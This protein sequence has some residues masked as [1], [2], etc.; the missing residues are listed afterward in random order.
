MKNAI[1]F[2]GTSC[3]PNSF[4]YPWLGKELKNRGYNVYIPQLPEADTPSLVNW[5]PFALK[6]V[7]FNLETVIIAHSA[8]VS[9]TLAVLENLI[10][11]VNKVILV[12][13]TA[14]QRGKTPESKLI[15]KKSYD[16]AKI[17]RNGKE[18]YF[19]HSDNDPW[20]R[21]DKDGRYLYDHLGG[22]QIIQ[23]EGHF[24]SNTFNQ[25]YEEFP[26]L[27]KLI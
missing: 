25:P 11:P 13:G 21:D 10:E 1:I 6:N 16:W 18:F 7:K 26:L 8:G 19:I 9:L 2:H 20:G 17:K 4:W 5:L 27:L 3:T 12:A 15:L 22:T 14:R 24:G 23:H